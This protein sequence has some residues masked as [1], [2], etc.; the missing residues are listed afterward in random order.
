MDELSKVA[1]VAEAKPTEPVISETEAAPVQ[2]KPKEETVGDVLAPETKKPEPKMV[3]EAALIKYKDLSKDQAKEIARLKASIEDGS[4]KSEI[5]DSI[6]EIAK[7]SGVDE[8]FL[9]KYAD[10][11]KQEVREEMKDSVESEL[12]P[13]KEKER[14]S[15]IDR[16]FSEHYEKAMSQLPELA[17]VANKETIKALSLNP[18]NRNKT[19]VQIIEESYGHLA[20]GK[21]TLDP[22][23]S[24]AGKNDGSEVDMEKAGKGGAYFDEVMANPV[25]K[26]KYNDAMTERLSKIL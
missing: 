9:Q 10:R 25:T 19:F 23:S 21:R 4:T 26:K 14:A 2:E 11:I 12:K 15:Q 16:L 3:P 13:I 8:T 7:E 1:P 22:A 20:S 18:E 6:K 17:N 24:R 5:R